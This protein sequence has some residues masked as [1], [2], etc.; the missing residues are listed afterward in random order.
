MARCIAISKDCATVATAAAALMA[1]GSEF[2]EELCRVCAYICR[3]CADEC[4]SHKA[5]HC[6][7]CADACE[8]CARECDKVISVRV[9]VTDASLRPA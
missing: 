7:R 3:A 8:R 1:A 5:E 9:W 2:T 4:R 6:Q